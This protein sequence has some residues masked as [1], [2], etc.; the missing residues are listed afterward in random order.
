MS[1]VY[2]ETDEY[3]INITAYNLHSDPKYGYH[4]FIHNIT[5]VIL[6][7][8]PV[9]DWTIDF[10]NPPRR[11]DSDGRNNGKEKILSI[12]QTFSI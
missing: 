5:R 11:I 6:T 8:H 3:V 9:Q 7:L 1:H 10:G 2:N 12:I 4:G